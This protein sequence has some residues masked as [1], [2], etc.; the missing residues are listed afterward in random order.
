MKKRFI[1]TLIMLIL[2]CSVALSYS[3]KTVSITSIPTSVKEFIKLRNEIS[4]TRGGAGALFVV[5]MIIY[6]KNHELGM[7]CFT[8]AL[9]RSRLSQSKAVYKGFSPGSSFRYYI[10]RLNRKPYIPYAYIQGTSYKNGYK[11]PAAPYK[12]KYIQHKYQK[13]KVLIFTT[14]GNMPRPIGLRKNNR[15]YYK[16]YGASSLFLGLSKNPQKKMQDDDL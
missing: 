5:A 15:G 16:T 8:L 1:L 6:T 13:K 4:T 9:D 2:F 11:L 3:A 14:S 12:I 10:K 7:K